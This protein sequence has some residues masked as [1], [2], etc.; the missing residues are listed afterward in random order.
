MT[1]QLTIDERS[2]R[3]QRLLSFLEHDPANHNL[4][5]DAASTAIDE[6]QFALATELLETVDGSPALLNLAGVL[7]LM[8]ER[9]GD[10][11]E[12]FSRLRE[13]G[14]DDPAIRFNLAWAKAMTGGF[15]MANELLDDDALAMSPRAPVLKIEAM[16]HLDLHEE[17][18]AVG[19]ALA[20]RF[21]DNEALMGALATL[22][23]DAGEMALAEGYAARAGDNPQ[24]LAARG[25]LMLDGESAAEAMPLFERALAA[26]PDNARAWIGQG[27]G[28]VSLGQ[29]A[30]GADALERGAD[31]FGDHLGSWIAAGWAHFTA[32]DQTKARACF[33]RAQSI[34]DTFA[35]S[36]GALAVLDILDGDVARGQQG[37]KVALRL[38]R[39]SLGGALAQSM[40][41]DK[42]GKTDAA[43]KVRQLALS[44]PIGPDGKTIADALARLARGRR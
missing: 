31:L 34:D 11:A 37:A 39:S 14:E 10:A 21:P 12:A 7:A 36:H 35:E 27:L 30:A 38:D 22:A 15:A 19:Q 25:M 4:R 9:F 33:E 32:G 20:E 2:P 42:S 17:A 24:G 43:E 3:L 1:A 29:S 23:M 28:L 26:R 41:L 44:A 5:A 6:R 18:L 13:S 16:H 40:L 8:E